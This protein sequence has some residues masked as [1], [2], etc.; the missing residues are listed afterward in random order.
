MQT[1]LYWLVRSED[2]S[3]NSGTGKV[4]QV[5]VFADNTAVVRWLKD[6]VKVKISS[7]VFYENA[8]DVE[9]IHGH[10]GRTKVVPIG[11]FS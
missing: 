8:E 6:A 11:E 10:E 3:F 4:A 5:A 2:V 1:G 7:T 9:R